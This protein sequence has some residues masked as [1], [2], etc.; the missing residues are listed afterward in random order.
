MKEFKEFFKESSEVLKTLGVAEE[1]G[2][3]FLGLLAMAADLKLLHD[4]A[5]TESLALCTTIATHW[6]SLCKVA[7]VAY[8]KCAPD[9]K[10]FLEG[11]MNLA[12]IQVE[13]LDNKDRNKLANLSNL[14]S[15]VIKEFDAITGLNLG[16]YNGDFNDAWSDLKSVAEAAKMT[17]AVVAGCSLLLKKFKE[18]SEPGTKQEKFR[19]WKKLC[20]KKRMTPSDGKS[21][22]WDFMPQALIEAL[23][24]AQR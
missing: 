8:G 19:D 9:W 22:V 7:V 21:T 5:T 14:V 20:M 16:E 6:V 13:L 11:A 10:P 24:S 3:C 12:Q 18:T 2:E 17:S 15:K 1:G 4:T 23:T